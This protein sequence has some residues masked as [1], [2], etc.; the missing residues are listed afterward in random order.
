MIAALREALAIRPRS[1]EAL[2]LLGEAFLK[3]G[4][5]DEAMTNLK[6]TVDAGATFEAHYHLGWIYLRKGDLEEAARQS[7]PT[8]R[9]S[10]RCRAP[11]RTRMTRKF[12][13]R[14]ADARRSFMRAESS[15]R[16]TA[17][18]IRT[19]LNRRPRATVL[20]PTGITGVLSGS[21]RTRGGAPGLAL[22]QLSR[23]YS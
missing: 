9:K 14:L 19:R 21:T 8:A 17:K 1:G 20:P 4:R 18:S 16:S 13:Y 22:P 3:S 6:W 11:L 2:T 7:R 15:P 12:Q 10:G 5:F 23:L